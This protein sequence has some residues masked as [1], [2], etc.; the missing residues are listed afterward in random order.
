MT[1]KK[2]S[3]LTD[4]EKFIEKER[5]RNWRI[6]NRNR[7]N[8]L[9]RLS[10]H[11]DINKSRERAKKNA[12]RIRKRKL[13]QEDIDYLN[14]TII[15]GDG[16]WF[17]TFAKSNGYPV[18]MNRKISRIMAE[19]KYGK[20]LNSSDIVMHSCDNPACVN[21]EHLSI[22]THKENVLDKVFKGRGYRQNRQNR[23]N[24]KTGYSSSKLT[25]EQVLEIR[26]LWK[27]MKFTQLELAK[28]FN[29]SHYTICDVVNY[30]SWKD[31]YENS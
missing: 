18:F 16:C 12:M 30:N 9:N 1:W 11:R 10:Y 28:R 31:L 22:G 7:H 13:K 25:A 14:S 20:E 5:M 15:K 21:P 23:Q 8:E 19:V 2:W 4:E 17:S 3:S 29:V 26:K 6:K 27:T 24:S